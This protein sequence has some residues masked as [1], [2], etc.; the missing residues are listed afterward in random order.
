MK[1]IELCPITKLQRQKLGQNYQMLRQEVEKFGKDYQKK[2]YEEI[3]SF[4]DQDVILKSIENAHI[5]CSIEAYHRQKNGTIAVSI[6][7]YG[8]PT[9]FGI[10]PSYHFYKRLDGSVYY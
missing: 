1:L 3:L 7:A 10:K 9:I 2:S 6:D 4:S 8:L 5:S